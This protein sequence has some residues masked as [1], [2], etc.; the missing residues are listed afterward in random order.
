MMTNEQREERMTN[1]LDMQEDFASFVSTLEGMRHQL[2]NSGWD[3]EVAR[4]L[5]YA[6][7][8]NGLTGGGV[9]IDDDE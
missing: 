9:A 2:V 7:I 1:L 5:V 3:D 8:M 4:S 6:V